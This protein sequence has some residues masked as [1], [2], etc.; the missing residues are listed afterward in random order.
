MDN[1]LNMAETKQAEHA[2]PLFK[3]LIRMRETGL[4]LIILAL[5]VTMSFASP[6][7]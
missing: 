7:F 6:F 5:F 3:R 4:I 1:T 2:A